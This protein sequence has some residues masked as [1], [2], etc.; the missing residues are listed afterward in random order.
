MIMRIMMTTMIVFCF[1][2]VILSDSTGGLCTHIVILSLAVWG[3]ASLVFT[4]Y[5]WGALR[6]KFGSTVQ[7]QRAHWWKVYNLVPDE[8]DSDVL[9][10]L[11]Y[12][13]LGQNPRLGGQEARASKKDRKALLASSS[14]YVPDRFGWVF[15]LEVGTPSCWEMENRFRRELWFYV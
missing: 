14:Q 1:P 8:P 12:Y 2:V 5:R 4:S 9:S 13:C 3:H 7:V 11:L 10:T 6:H 15:I